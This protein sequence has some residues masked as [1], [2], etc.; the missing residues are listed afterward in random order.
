METTTK[1]AITIK[2][3]WDDKANANKVAITI[4]LDE[5]NNTYDDY[6]PATL[7]VYDDGLHGQYFEEYINGLT[8]DFW[9]Q[10]NL[11]TDLTKSDEVGECDL[12]GDE[13]ELASRD[14]RCGDCGNC[15][16]CCEDVE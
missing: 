12:C 11:Y 4:E 7:I 6:K 14:G 2:E 13:Y 10:R 5:P 8:F 15:A 9:M 3:V 16:K 1:Y